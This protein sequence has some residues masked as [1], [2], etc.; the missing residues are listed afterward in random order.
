MF[1]YV[2]LLALGCYFEDYYTIFSLFY[3]Y[4]DA[5]ALY[6]IAVRLFSNPSLTTI[7]HY[8]LRIENCA[9]CIASRVFLGLSVCD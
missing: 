2:F 3:Y 1:H 9:L 6:G 7:A 4:F 5:V 8:A